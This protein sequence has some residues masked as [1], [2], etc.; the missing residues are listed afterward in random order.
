MTKESSCYICGK[1]FSSV[2][3]RNS[4]IKYIHS[5]IREKCEICEVTLGHAFLRYHYSIVHGQ[6]PKKDKIYQCDQ[7]E[8][9][10][11]S[12]GQLMS[13][14][15]GVHL[16]QKDYK[17]DQCDGQFWKKISLDKHLKD[18]H[19]KN[20]ELKKYQCENCD[21]VT[22]HKVAVKHHFDRIHLKKK[23]HFCNV[24][25]KSFGGAPDLRRHLAMVHKDLSQLK[26]QS[27]HKCE[28]CD[29]TSVSKKNV[30]RHNNTIHLKKLDHVCDICQKAFGCSSNL[31]S[32]MAQVHKDLSQ[33]PNKKVHNCQY[34]NYF[35]VI[36]LNVIRHIS[37]KH[38]KRSSFECLICQKKYINQES[39]KRHQ[40]FHVQGNVKC[41]V[42][43]ALFL[44]KSYM[45]HHMQQQHPGPNVKTENILTCPF[46]NIQFLKSHGT[47]TF[48]TT[49]TKKFH[50]E[51]YAGMS[52]A[53]EHKCKSCKY[54]SLLK[55]NLKRHISEKH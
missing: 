38:E 35:S 3:N 13:H 7:C 9:A 26:S 27:I 49:H 29:Y 23:N 34:C 28:N 52:Q 36:K 15:K 46:C 41:E 53:K 55:R 48:L 51:E 33:A 1:I 44:Q 30:Q 11:E 22:I 45:R 21:F 54:T 2:S 6:K 20:I 40:N 5:N 47:T 31:R 19:K 50:Q 39:F 32:H 18:I 10:V 24:C 4:H 43:P 17:C 37:T 25:Q 14:N 12:R 42:C 16:K 8:F